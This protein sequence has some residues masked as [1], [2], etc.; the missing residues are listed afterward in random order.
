MKVTVHWGGDESWLRG[1]LGLCGA[2]TFYCCLYCYYMRNTKYLASQRI[3]RNLSQFGRLKGAFDH[4]ME[5]LIEGL[6][7]NV[8]PCSLH[9]IIPFGKDLLTFIANVLAN[10]PQQQQKQ[11]TEQVQAWITKVDVPIEIGKPPLF[12]KWNIKGEHTW[13]LFSNPKELL[14][15]TLGLLEDSPALAIMKR[16]KKHMRAAYKFV[17][18]TG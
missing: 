15:L 5:P 12:G 11:R 9:A 8:H 3:P 7:T 10:L 17:F 13:W 6:I 16:M 18:H 1:W 4:I 2:K 14:C